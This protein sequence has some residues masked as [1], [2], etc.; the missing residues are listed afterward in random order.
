VRLLLS[1]ATAISILAVALVPLLTPFWTH[2]AHQLSYSAGDSACLPQ[3]ET[4]AACY[5]LSGSD[6][7]EASDRSIHALIITG[8]FSFAGPENV[9]H[10]QPFYTED[11]QSHLRD[12]R[13]VLYGFLLLAVVSAVFVIVSL[14]RGARDAARWR[15]VARGALWLIPAIVLLGVFAFFAFEPLFT[16]FHE[17]FFP[18]GN[19]SFPADS[20]MILTYPEL[21]WE[22]CSFALGTLAIIGS[23]I[24]W[25]L[26]RRRAAALEAG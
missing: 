1:L 2:A 9:S 13:V 25:F 7:I 22:L 20:H 10:G 3:G 8:D 24:V 17:I 11:E 16:L 4:R 6:V 5:G 21:F 12:A 19:W 26:A 15:A 18:G 14:V 23:T